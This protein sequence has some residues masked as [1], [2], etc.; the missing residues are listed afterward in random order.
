M[1]K[2]RLGLNR[3][4]LAIVG[5]IIALLIWTLTIAF[6]YSSGESYR[7]KIVGYD[8]VDLLSGHYLRFRY[9]F[10]QTPICANRPES[11]TFC[12][13]Y[14]VNETNVITSQESYLCDKAQK[15]CKN[16]IQGVCRAGTFLT[17]SERYYFPEKYAPV[18]ALVPENSYAEVKVMSDGKIALQNIFVGESPILDY[19]EMSL[20]APKP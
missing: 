3:E 5:P 20:A 7:V 6:T 13:C 2:A 18:L 1:I 11:A 19:A 16:Y 9:D 14:S 12:A 15:V 17:G 4:T 8:P 10:G